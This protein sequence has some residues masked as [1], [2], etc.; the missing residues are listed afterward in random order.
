MPVAQ[1][2]YVREV[3]VVKIREI[4]WIFPPAR[5]LRT[6]N[7]NKQLILIRNST[8]MNLVPKALVRDIW[9]VSLAKTSLNFSREELR[10]KLFVAFSPPYISGC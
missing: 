6:G 1:E 9:P 7:K 3:G 10:E 2:K 8:T 4:H 5:T